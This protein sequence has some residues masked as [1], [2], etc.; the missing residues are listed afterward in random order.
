MPDLIFMKHDA[1]SFSIGDAVTQTEGEKLPIGDDHFGDHTADIALAGFSE[2]VAIEPNQ[3]DVL[4]IF[5]L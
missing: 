4:Q 3:I 2:A 5:Y 1:D